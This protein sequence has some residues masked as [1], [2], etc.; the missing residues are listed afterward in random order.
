MT[1]SYP[2]TVG[3]QQSSCKQE[4][5]PDSTL[6]V[7]YSVLPPTL[8]SQVVWKSISNLYPALLAEGVI[9]SHSNAAGAYSMNESEI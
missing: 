6:P 1:A 9:L 3:P 7:N 5:A 4:G 8:H 2:W